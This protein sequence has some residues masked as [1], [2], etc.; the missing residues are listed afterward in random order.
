MDENAGVTLRQGQ[1]AHIGPHTRDGVKHA[2]HT[3]QQITP[4]RVR[5]QGI[6]IL[7]IQQSR[8]DAVHLAEIVTDTGAY[9]PQELIGIMGGC[10]PQRLPSEH[11]RRGTEKQDG[12]NHH[13]AIRHGDRNLDTVGLQYPGQSHQVPP[14]PWWERYCVGV[15]PHTFLKVEE[16]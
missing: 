5:D 12:K 3:R 9:L 2:A 7:I 10:I 11:Q 4:I 13:Q 16:K 15:I 8:G 14:P 1:Q 6:H